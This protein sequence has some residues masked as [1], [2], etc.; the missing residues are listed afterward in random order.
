MKFKPFLVS[1]FMCVFLCANAVAVRAMEFSGANH[2]LADPSQHAFFAHG[3]IEEG[4]AERLAALLAPTDGGETILFVSSDG[5]SVDAAFELAAVISEH[6]DVR[7]NVVDRCAS[8]CATILFPAA[9]TSELLLN[10]QL[11][12]H[13]CHEGST[14]QSQPECNERIAER[15]VENGFPY[16]AVMMWT[17]DVPADEVVWVRYAFARC[18]GYY[19][20]DGDPV[21]IQ[22]EQPC[23]RGIMRTMSVPLGP[24]FFEALL[25]ADCGNPAGNTEF[26]LCRERELRGMV[27]LAQQLYEIALSYTPEDEQ[28]Q[29]DQQHMD[30]ADQMIASCPAEGILEEI[31]SDTKR[32]RE[33]VRCLADKLYERIRYLDEL[34]V[35]L[36]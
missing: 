6:G 1:L 17:Q 15:A 22:Q 26:M 25:V 29:L 3:V 2:L 12:F 14:R 34:V 23:V 24:H 28:R 36:T 10:A 16:G 21:P 4:D 5:G 13:S 27:V 9:R 30:W 32:A 7:L 33:P 20:R 31:F 11:G 18:F 19:R 8:A 35:D